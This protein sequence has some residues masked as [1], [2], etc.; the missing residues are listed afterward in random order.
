[1]S[2]PSPD[3][4]LLWVA[5]AHAVAGAIALA[6]IAFT[7]S[8]TPTLGDHPALK[9]M[10][11]G[12]SIALFL[13]T[14][15]WLLP[16]MTLAPGARAAIAWVLAVGMVVEMAAIGGQ[17]LRG[18]ASHFNQVTALDA[19]IWRVMATTIVAVTVATLVVVVVAFVRPLAASPIQAAAWRGG[20][21][22]FVLATLTGFRMA[23]ALSH[24]VAPYG[25]LRLAHAVGVHALQ[26][27]PLAG[28]VLVRLPVGEP[29]RW[30]LLA[31]AV[32][33]HVAVAAWALLRSA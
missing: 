32:A 10:K 31:V 1:V 12:F 11:F 3:R 23:S 25:D 13:G 27:L 30:L 26:S 9:P 28:A 29:A 17:A 16:S 20:L 22:F 5:L 24:T 2:G 14:M 19:L 8:A 6:A 18:A 33:V 4:L 15:A 21:A 7:A